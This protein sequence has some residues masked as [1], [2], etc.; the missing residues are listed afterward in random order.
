LL[1]ILNKTEIDIKAGL[2]I[3][4]VKALFIYFKLKMRVFDEFMN[5]IDSYDPEIQNFHNNTFLLFI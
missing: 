1:Q 4:E 5:L 2:T 3:E